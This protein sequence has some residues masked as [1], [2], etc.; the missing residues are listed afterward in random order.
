MLKVVTLF[1]NRDGLTDAEWSMPID[2]ARVWRLAMIVTEAEGNAESVRTG[3]CAEVGV[4]SD[5]KS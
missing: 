4:L 3:G 5:L 1:F 2:V